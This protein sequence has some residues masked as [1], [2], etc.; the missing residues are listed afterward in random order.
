VAVGEQRRG[1]VDRIGGGGE[2]GQ[3]GGDVAARLA[4][5]ARRAAARDRRRYR[6]P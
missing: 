3:L 2:A 6:R 5:P 1:D 4:A